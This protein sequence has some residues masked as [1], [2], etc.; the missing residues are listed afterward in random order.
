VQV[1]PGSR[2]PDGDPLFDSW[3]LDGD[4]TF[5]T[6]LAL[7]PTFTYMKPGKVTAGLRGQDGAA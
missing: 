6:R 1:G 7:R 2:D 3:D 5:G 4:G